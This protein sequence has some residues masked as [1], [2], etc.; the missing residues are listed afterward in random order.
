MRLVDTHCHLY[1]PPLKEDLRQVMERARSSGVERIVVPG[2]D[3]GS[4]GRAIDIS[5]E[6][7]EVFAAAGIHPHDSQKASRESME[8]LKNMLS[9]SEKVVAVGEIGLDNYRK[10]SDPESQVKV[11]SGAAAMACALDLPVIVHCRRAEHEVLEVLRSLPAGFLRG[12]LHCFSGDADFLKE[13]LDL[14]M[15]VSFT[16]N[17]T[18]PGEKK[19]REIASLVPPERLLLETDSPYMTPEQKRGSRNEPSFVKYLTDVFSGI[20][21]MEPDEIAEITTRNADSLFGLGLGE[22][23]KIAYVI[24]NSLYLNLTRRCTNRCGF[25][26]RN[27]SDE[28]KGH[29]LRLSREPGYPEIIAEIGDPSKFDEIVFCGFGEPTLRLGIVKRIAAY[30]KERGGKVRLTTN[31]EADL[32]WGRNVPS[33]LKGLVDRVSISL[34]APDRGLY[35]SICDPVF[36]KRTFDGI[37]GFMKECREE[38]IEVEVTCVDLIGE[39]AVR[40]CRRIAEEHGANFR[41]RHLDVVG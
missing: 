31:G 37:L 16:G 10:Y 11:F 41:L 1:L 3:I 33:E 30:V 15:Y 26:A 27:S 7:P 23:G 14:G 19:L 24:R 21:G 29:N 8:E 34:N 38:D 40:S 28:V 12:V 13:I 4:S 18:Y 2:I 17:I 6:Y 35:E 36:G 22:Q 25:C 5:G 9:G 20:L 39:D 32:I